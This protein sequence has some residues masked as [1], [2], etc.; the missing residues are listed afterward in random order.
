MPNFNFSV[1]LK[2]PTTLTEVLADKLLA[3]G[4]D[5]ATP[6]SSGGTVSIDFG[7]EASDLESA[8]CSARANVRAAGCIIDRVELAPT[9]AS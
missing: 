2:S 8:F 5:D 3:A 9:C 7:R 4:C 1:I 6:S